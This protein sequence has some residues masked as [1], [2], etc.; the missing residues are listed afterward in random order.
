VSAPARAEIQALLKRLADGD[1]TAIEPAFAV[2]WELVRR[3]S[4]RALPNS[5]DAEDAAQQAL[6]KVFE[7][8]V[9]FDSSRD[10]IGWVLTIA[11][12]ECRTI[13]RRRQRRREDGLETAERRFVTET[14][15]VLVMNRDLEAAVR[16][17]LE[18]LGEEDARTILA[19]MRDERPVAD[20]TFRKRL[21]RAL[22]RLRLAWRAKHEHE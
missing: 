19:A 6:T 7:Q 9:D 8:A 11:A 13:R 5:A 18:T 22:G 21:Q 17:V 12:F 1:R 15:E 3:F 10:G 4:A 2:L 20:A 16:E 14:P